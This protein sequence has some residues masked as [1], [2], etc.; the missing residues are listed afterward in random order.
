MENNLTE[1]AANLAK[2]LEPFN[3]ELGKLAEIMKQQIKGN[4]AL[5]KEYATA[6][7]DA[8]LKKRFDDLQKELRSINH[9]FRK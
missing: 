1:I 4:P 2:S 3:A 6:L 7:K 8:D 9:T 5:A